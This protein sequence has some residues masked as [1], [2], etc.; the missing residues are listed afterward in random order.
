MKMKENNILVDKSIDFAIRM[1][2]CFKFLQIAII[3]YY[4]SFSETH[5][6]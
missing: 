2:N 6:P 5:E 1:V 3:I 4:F